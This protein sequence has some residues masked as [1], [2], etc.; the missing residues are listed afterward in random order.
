MDKV[1]G[2]DPKHYEKFMGQLHAPV[3]GLEEGF[4]NFQMVL[5]KEGG[6]VT[7]L[8]LAEGKEIEWNFDYQILCITDWSIA[9]KYTW[10]WNW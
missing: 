10:R 2:D 9:W 8:E 7:V 4:T 5:T 1:S 3:P 6:E